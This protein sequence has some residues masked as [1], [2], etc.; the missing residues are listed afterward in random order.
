MQYPHPPF[1]NLMGCVC[2]WWGGGGT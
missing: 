1:L 2:A